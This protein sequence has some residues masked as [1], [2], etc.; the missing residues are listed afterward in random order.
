MRYTICMVESTK[1]TILENESLAT[2]V[3]IPIGN[4]RYIRS[5]LKYYIQKK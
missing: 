1:R 4:N 2:K 3:P 5:S